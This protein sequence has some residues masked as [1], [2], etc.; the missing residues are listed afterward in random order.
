[1][2]ILKWCRK[3]FIGVLHPKNK[4]YQY[5]EIRKFD[6]NRDNINW[7]C[8]MFDEIFVF[9]YVRNNFPLTRLCKIS[10]IQC[11]R[12]FLEQLELC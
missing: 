5:R 8:A 1:M 7:H 3:T 11:I 12:N 10:F 9:F 6:N 4:F 2:T